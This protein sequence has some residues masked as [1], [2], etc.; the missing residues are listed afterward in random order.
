MKK[1]KIFN[2][3]GLGFAL[4]LSVGS[5][6]AALAKEKNDV[7]ILRVCNWEEYIDLGDWDE[8]EAIELDNG[9]RILGE[10]PMYEDFEGWYRETYGKEVRVEY[11]CA[12]TNEDLYNQLNL[13]DTYDLICPSEYMIMKLMAEGRLQPYSEAF[14]DKNEEYNYYINN[15]SPYIQETLSTNE[16]HGE[17]WAKYAAGY[18]WGITGVLYNPEQVSAQEAGTWE[19]FNNE[20]YAR[21]VTLKDNVRDTYFAALGI[22]K[23]D[24]LMDEGFRAD[25]GYHEKLGSE[26]NDVRQE[27]IDAVETL[28]SGMMD[29]VYALETDSGKADMVTGK[30]VANYQWSGDAVYAMNQA[31][32]DGSVLKFA[33]PRECTNLWFD[34]WVMLKDGIG[35]DA[36][37]QHA[38]EAFVNFLSRPDNAVRNMYYIGYTSAISGGEGDSTMLDYVKYCYGSEDSAEILYPVGYFFGGGDTQEEYWIPATKEQA[39]GQLFAQYPPEE[40][41][42]R[43]AVMQYFD[44]Q[45]NQ[46]INQMWINIRCYNIMETPLIVWLLILAAIMAALWFHGMKRL[47]RT[48][49]RTV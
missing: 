12:G 1:R 30:V 13:G 16:I 44:G 25:E 35:G 21:Q 26:M 7:T 42:E 9:A 23:A 6:S 3:F 17:S 18:M 36:Q 46:A 47:S 2:L 32:E 45:A 39:D 33:V 5:A 4:A 22:L 38:A 8:D 11:S 43:A 14:Y 24:L 31:Q 27:T 34:G 10:N 28:L 37:R 41:I 19:I 40:I 49:K 15:V 20:K 29:N 48:L